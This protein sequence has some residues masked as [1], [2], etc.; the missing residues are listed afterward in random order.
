MMGINVS[1]GVFADLE[2]N[3]S[4]LW[5]NRVNRLLDKQGLIPLRFHGLEDRR[6]R[7][8]WGFFALGA[9]ATPAIPWLVQ[10]IE[11]KPVPTEE[12]YELDFTG[13]AAIPC[14]ITKLTKEAQV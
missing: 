9:D 4:M 2:G 12:L 3:L 10:E 14:T 6:R 11:A 5:Q 8:K 1:L 13:K 7:A